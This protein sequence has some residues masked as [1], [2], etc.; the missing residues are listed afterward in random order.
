MNKSIVAVLLV[1]LAG[2]SILAFNPP[3]PLIKLMAKTDVVAQ[4]AKRSYASMLEALPAESSARRSDEGWELSAPDGS[5]AFFWDPSATREN[6]RHAAVLRTPVAPFLEAGL[7]PELLPEGMVRDGMLTFSVDADQER[8]ESAVSGEETPASA[9]DAVI[10][11]CRDRIGY[12]FQLGHFGLELDGGALLE[13]AGDL[14][15]NN[16]DLVFA[17]DPETLIRAGVN[18]DH[19]AGWTLGTIIVHDPSG[20]KVEVPKFLKPFNL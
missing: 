4:Y 6:G 5:A 19:V 17:L 2:I 15:E 9:F 16:L 20:R 7:N 3:A 10:D 13:W 12:H 18:G 11:A 8:G 14:A 1:V